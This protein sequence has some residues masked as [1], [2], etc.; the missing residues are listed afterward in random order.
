MFAHSVRN[1]LILAAAL[2]ASLG[3]QSLN[4]SKVDALAEA[5][6]KAWQAPGCA[7]AIIQGD[8]VVYQKGYGVKE[9]GNPDPVT[10]K[11]VFAIGSTTKAFTTAILAMLNDEGRLQW[12]DPVRKYLP[13]FQ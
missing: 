4:T 8:R 2:L 13:D 6:L 11:T 10:T 5:A 12:D 7:I 3:A 9:L 1:A